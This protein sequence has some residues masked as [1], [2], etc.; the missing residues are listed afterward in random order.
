MTHG[1]Q[2]SQFEPRRPCGGGSADDWDIWPTPDGPNASKPP[3]YAP[4]LCRMRQMAPVTT[5]GRIPVHDA[6]FSGECQGS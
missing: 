1:L 4:A 6:G 2:R 5:D 3:V